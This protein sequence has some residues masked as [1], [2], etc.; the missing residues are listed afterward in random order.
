MVCLSLFWESVN[1]NYLQVS[2]LRQE[3]DVI[4]TIYLIL[5]AEINVFFPTP[6]T[7]FLHIWK[8]QN[9]SSRK[10]KMCMQCAINLKTC[11]SAQLMIHLIVFLLH[12]VNTNWWE[13]LIQ[14]NIWRKGALKG[15][16]QTI[17]KNIKEKKWGMFVFFSWNDLVK[18]FITLF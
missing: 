9:C 1:Y 2:C 16:T 3:Y 10:L 4:I 17:A 13:I 8:V 7:F 14:L 15:K 18:H 6:K 5:L 12:S 11:K